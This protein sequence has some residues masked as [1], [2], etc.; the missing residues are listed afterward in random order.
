MRCLLVLVMSVSVLE[1]E[2][3]NLW[4]GE[5]PG[6]ARSEEGVESVNKR[7]HFT[8]IEVP[9]YELFRPEK[10][11]GM[12]LVIFPGGGYG[13]LAMGHEGTEVGEWCA[14]RGITAM[15]V[16]YRVSRKEGFGYQFPVPQLDGRRAI[17]TMRF[18]AEEW[19]LD[20]G[21]IGVMGFSAGGHLASTCVTLFEEKLEEG[22][23]DEIDAVSCRPDFGV[24]AYP[25]IGMNEEW[26]HGGSRKNL[27]GVDAPMALR[28]RV[29][30]HLRVTEKTP[31][32][33]LVHSADDEPVP[34]RN[35]A[36]FMSA[37]AE[38][39]VPVRAAIY[40]TGGHLASTC[41]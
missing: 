10:P 5:A 21:R 40:A 20:E 11:N 31:P 23:G 22:E 3:V 37:C 30:T 32:I 4:E 33:F 15:V 36:E 27:L 2:W 7:G 26:G 12:G 9:Q 17:R 8:D 35:S 39:G 41:V 19:G 13:I 18:R 25:V 34:L 1:G 38:K 29:A 6:A 16:K 24:L 14:E 28:E